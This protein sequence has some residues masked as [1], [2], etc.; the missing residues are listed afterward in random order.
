MIFVAEDHPEARAEYL[1][2]V[3]YYDEQRAG[4][5]SELLEQFEEAVRAI[6][7][8]PTAWTLVSYPEEQPVLRSRRTRTFRHR[9]VYYV[10]EATIRIVAYAHTGQEPGYWRHRL[11][12]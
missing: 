10:R 2:A 4:L 11:D 5:G 12:R 9:V 1:R 7:D 3:A 8:D 6:V